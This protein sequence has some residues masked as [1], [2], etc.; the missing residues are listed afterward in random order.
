MAN[1]EL[2]KKIRD[3]IKR[4]PKAFAMADWED[5]L[6]GYADARGDFDVAYY[7]ANE[8][9]WKDATASECGTTRC[10][11]GWAI[12]FEAERRGMDVSRPLD[13]L[14]IDLGYEY[15]FTYIPTYGE[16][17]ARVLGISEE[18][19]SLF[20]IDEESAYEIVNEFAE[21]LRN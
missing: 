1:T 17:G 19:S 15:G 6:A 20:F 8:R 16:L 13:A 7:D 12:H 10:V 4:D 2:F 14:R 11:A 21:G 5:D 18:E 3:Q 9:E